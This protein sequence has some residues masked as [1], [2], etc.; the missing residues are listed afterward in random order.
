MPE[1]NDYSERCNQCGEIAQFIPPS[2]I[3]KK[4]KKM[5]VNYRCPNGHSFVR[6]HDIK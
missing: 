3:D 1:K 4:R 5:I 2:E 6:E